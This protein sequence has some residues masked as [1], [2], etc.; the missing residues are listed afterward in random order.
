[1]YK[2]YSLNV[3]FR[4]PK[5]RVITI[6][7]SLIQAADLRDSVYGLGMIGIFLSGDGFPQP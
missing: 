1:M 5:P 2:Q 4:C 3:A 6:R 7:G